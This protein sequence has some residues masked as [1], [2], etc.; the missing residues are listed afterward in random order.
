MFEESSLLIKS[1]PFLLQGAFA[2]IQIAFVSIAMGL[3]GGILIGVLN[4][5]KMR[6]SYFS[7]HSQWLCMDYKRNTSVCSVLIVYYALPEVDRNFLI[8]IYCRSDCPWHQ[9]HGVYFG[10]CTRR[11]QCYS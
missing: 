6:N 1:L 3:C 11:H 8:A 2:T 10:N 7:E 9:F 5:N 4:C